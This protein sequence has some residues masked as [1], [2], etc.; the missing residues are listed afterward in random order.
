MQQQPQGM[1]QQFM[2]GSQVRPSAMQNQMNPLPYV[3]QPQQPPSNYANN[4]AKNPSAG[5]VGQQSQM[6]QGN[7][8]SQN[9]QAQMRPNMSSAQLD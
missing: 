7:M 2:L 6:M 9:A 8:P 5:Y 4:I 1:N 3:R